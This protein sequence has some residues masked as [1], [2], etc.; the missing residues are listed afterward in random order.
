MGAAGRLLRNGF[1]HCAGFATRPVD[2]TPTSL[3]VN[4]NMGQEMIMIDMSQS[5]S[6]THQNATRAERLKASKRLRYV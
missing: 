4:K 6:H 2:A 1:A 3:A 5:N